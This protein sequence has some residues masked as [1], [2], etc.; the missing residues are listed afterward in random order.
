MK[1]TD[2]KVTLIKGII[3]VRV[4]TDEG[5]VGLGECSGMN[6]PV[7][8]SVVEDSL[9]PLLIGENPL[10]IERLWEKMYVKTY[11]IR[12]QSQSIGI[13]GV[14]IALWDILGK[15]LNTPVYQ[16]LG[17]CY[18]EKIRMYA[19]SVPRELQDAVKSAEM[20]VQFVEAGFTA[21]KVKV[22]TRWGFDDLPDLAVETVRAIREA[23]GPNID[24]MVD[25]N[26]AYTAHT[27][28][29]LGR[30][31]EEYNIFHFEE[32]VPFHDLGAMAQ[33]AAALDVPLAGGEQDHTRYRFKEILMMDAVDIVQCDV[34]KAGGLSEC[35][36]IAAMAD[37]F[38][39]PV[40][41]HNTNRTVGMAATLHFLA[42]T[43][44]A[45]YSQECTIL[46]G[47]KPD[48]VRDE[49]LTKPFKVV[50]GF[51]EVPKGP[52]LGVELN[53]EIVA[54]YGT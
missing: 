36:K 24:L 21:L 23:I 12:G 33:V 46:P 31:F 47:R 16:L 27:A 41:P 53:E 25:A 5:I 52:G 3:L 40:T 50:A 19:S 43:P 7:I 30:K 45:R 44:N 2:V 8:R 34:I 20:A 6:G 4:Y 37:A 54:K 26:S 11:K 38:G 39:R 28:I 35:K 48:S 13:S 42:S 17:G 32:P 49:L 22:G 15:A 18:R 29:R 51:L 1:I 14:D 9:R 10:D